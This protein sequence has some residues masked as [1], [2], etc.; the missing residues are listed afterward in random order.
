MIVTRETSNVIAIFD[1]D[2]TLACAAKRLKASGAEPTRDDLKEYQRYLDHLQSGDSL[3]HD[4]PIPQL[5]F[6]ART[7]HQWGV[8]VLYVTGR[9]EKYRKL[10]QQWLRSNHLPTAE[11]FMRALDDYREPGEYKE[12]VMK[13]IE[14]RTGDHDL[15]VF[16]D[17]ADGTAAPMYARHGWRHLKVMPMG[18]GL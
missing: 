6:L 4:A 13:G 1:L 3:L 12:Q 17:D 11:I 16:D 10:T 9:S 5:C 18:D 7:L 15:L 14:Y 8:E 2:N